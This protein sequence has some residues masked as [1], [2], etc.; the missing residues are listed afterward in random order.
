M[1][2]A[3]DIE[4]SKLFGLSHKI[5]FKRKVA[6]TFVNNGVNVTF[7]NEVTPLKK[8]SVSISANGII[9]TGV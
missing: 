7:M 6:S 8:C 9:D 2:L 4:K 5:D 1:R 3:Y